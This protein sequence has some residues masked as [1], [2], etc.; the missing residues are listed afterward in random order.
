MVFHLLHTYKNQLFCIIAK[1]TQMKKIFL[2]SISILFVFC[3]QSKAQELKSLLKNIEGVEIFDKAA[4]NG[5]SESYILNVKMPIDHTDE[6]KG[7]F[8]QRV[9][10]THRSFDAPTVLVTE[11]YSA[12]HAKLSWYIEE[13]TSLLNANQIVIEHRFFGKS[14]PEGCP[15]EYLTVMQAAADHHKIISM[16][17][18]F[19]KGKWVTTGASKG[20]STCVYH[21]ALYPD[22]VEATV[23]YVAPFTIADEDP[24]CISYLKT[25]GTDSVRRKILEFQRA[26]LKNRNG[27]KKYISIDIKNAH[28]TLLMSLD[29]TLDYMVVEYPF[30]FFQ[31]CGNTAAIPAADSKP[32]TLYKH[33]KKIIEPTTY[34]IHDQRKTGAFFVQAYNEVGYYGYDTLGLGNLLSINSDYISNKILVPKSAQINYNPDMLDFVRDYIKTDAKN[35]IFIYGEDDPWSATAAVCGNN[36]NVIFAMDKNNCHNVRISDMPD[37]LHNEIIAKLEEWLSVKI[38]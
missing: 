27:M 5:Y 2:V 33:L 20:G 18:P 28:D 29:S 3:I 6:S 15:W 4:V 25:I 8:T 12:E 24:R 14:I 30:A 7:F 21:R 38:K 35:I 36:K 34:G 26:V 31:Y 16:I 22:D 11:G 19:Y 1:I 32:A 37:D 10:I 13:L 17:K 23:S 9:F